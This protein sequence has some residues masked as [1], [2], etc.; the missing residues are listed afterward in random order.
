MNLIPDFRAP[1]NLRLG[2][3]PIYTRY[4][5]IWEAVQRIRR[6]VEERIYERYSAERLAVT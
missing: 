2:I 3:A 1:D 5:E 6:V 4:V